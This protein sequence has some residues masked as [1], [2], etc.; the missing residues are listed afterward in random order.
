[1]VTFVLRRLLYSI[2][3]LITAS[4][5]IF[6][7]V[8]A[9]GDPLAT[10][11]QNPLIS[12]VTL[13]N[14]S[15]K[16]HLDEPM[17]IRYG[18][19]VQEAVT[20][21]FGTPL[22]IEEPIWNDL[23]RVIPHTLQLVLLSELFAITF[24]IA[25][26]VYSAIRQ[27][28]LFDYATTAFSF[29]GFAMPVFW[30]ALMLQILFTN[31]AIKYDIRIFYTSGLSSTDAGTG[32]SF[33]V[34]RLQHLAIPAMT[35]AVVSMAQYSRYMR[36]G[37]LEVINSDY[38]RAARAKGLSE[39]KV[40]MKHA[41]R[42]A[43]IPVVT[44][45]ALNFGALIGGAVITESIFGLDGMGPYFLNNLLSQDAYPVMAWLMVVATMVVTFNLVADILYARLDPRIR[46]E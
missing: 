20:D 26:G 18:Y 9:A 43:L 7:S 45:S 44:I 37:M 22:L 17:L 41:F 5:L 46:Y 11:K 2:P 24:G 4:F 19:W 29:L 13:Q 16:K 3:V 14:I 8:S 25:I 10:L 28:S 34:D 32:L 39:T 38:V 1:M 33:V 35:L 21:K 27:Y 30:L 36:A 40:T 31:I 6:I 12:D 42:N 15:E 23:K